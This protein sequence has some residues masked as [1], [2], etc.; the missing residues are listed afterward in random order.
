MQ[1]Q[2]ENCSYST[3]NKLPQRSLP[4]YAGGLSLLK[5]QHGKSPCLTYIRVESLLWLYMY[6]HWIQRE[7]EGYIPVYPRRTSK[8]GLG[9]LALRHTALEVANSLYILRMRARLC[10]A[11]VCL[12]ATPQ[13]LRILLYWYTCRRSWLPC[14][15]TQ[16]G[17]YC[18]ADQQ[19]VKKNKKIFFGIKM[20][21][22]FAKENNNFFFFF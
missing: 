14:A 12:R 1:M 16:P 18:I 21:M 2:P 8:W 3:A 19:F 4:Q 7:R 9:L 15:T 11:E 17:Y 6:T 5:R 20:L 10:F 22:L 13:I